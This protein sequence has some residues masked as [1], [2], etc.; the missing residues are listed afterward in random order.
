[1][2]RFLDA[3][4]NQSKSPSGDG[5][6]AYKG[7]IVDAGDVLGPR[8]GPQLVDESEELLIHPSSVDNNASTQPSS[9]AATDPHVDL[10]NYSDQ[11]QQVASRSSEPLPNTVDTQTYFADNGEGSAPALPDR[12]STNVEIDQPSMSHRSAFSFRNLDPLFYLIVGIAAVGL[13]VCLYALITQNDAYFEREYQQLQKESAALQARLAA[14]ARLGAAL[15]AATAA[16][17]DTIVA[18]ETVVPALETSPDDVVETPVTRIESP[19]P[20]APRVPVVEI[21]TPEPEIAVSEVTAADAQ[22]PTE[23]PQQ[24][25]VAEQSSGDSVLLLLQQE[26]ES[27]RAAITSQDEKIS[28]LEQDNFELTSILGSSP[29][30]ESVVSE[31][32]SQVVSQV[33]PQAPTESVSQAVSRPVSSTAEASVVVDNTPATPSQSSPSVSIKESPRL[34]AP[35]SASETEMTDLVKQGY[36]AYHAENFTKAS[37][38]YGKALEFDPYDRDANLGVAATAHALSDFKLAEDR[39]RHLLTLDPV[40][41]VAFSALLNLSS[42][43]GQG[44]TIEFELEQHAQYVNDSQQLYAIL[45]NYYSHKKR[46]VD[47][48]KFYAIAVQGGT[49]NPDYWFNYAVALDNLGRTERAAEYYSQALSA[50]DSAPYSF[51]EIV[52][53]QRLQSLLT[54]DQ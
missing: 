48:E 50:I 35:V 21:Q 22:P 44:S 14:S 20:E 16:Q 10:T 28:R 32:A 6:R 2:S 40:D 4:R 52:A 19:D 23:N 51:D 18:A 12:A 26:M 46:W 15:T 11:Q 37:S 33:V 9:G 39:Y 24:V 45:G 47:A 7:K 38:F 49:N 41:E 5:A 36:L 13:F 54:V 43:G 29:V 42:S 17:T 1:M 8:V 3:I 25:G 53:R 31:P 30:E 34:E 27:L